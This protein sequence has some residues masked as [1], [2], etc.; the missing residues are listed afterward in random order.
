[1][2]QAVILGVTRFGLEIWKKALTKDVSRKTL[3]ALQGRLCNTIAGAPFRPPYSHSS[4]VL[5]LASLSMTLKDIIAEKELNDEGSPED[6]AFADF[7]CHDARE[8]CVVAPWEKRNFKVDI[9]VKEKVI[10]EAN[11]TA[12]IEELRIYTD[13]SFIDEKRMYAKTGATAVL[14][15]DLGLKEVN[16]AALHGSANIFNAEMA[17]VVLPP[18]LAK[19]HLKTEHRR[20]V[21]FV[22]SQSVIKVLQSHSG[23]YGVRVKATNMLTKLAEQVE[24]IIKGV[25]SHC[26]IKGNEVADQIDKIAAKTG[27]PHHPDLNHSAKWIISRCFRRRRRDKLTME[28]LSMEKNGLLSGSDLA[29]R[30]ETPR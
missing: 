4:A 23:K 5:N 11:E 9:P 29:V 10:S 6:R 17:G 20:L 28:W 2:Y 16:T 30:G 21:I 14:L 15:D 22:D 19:R 26:E 7:V 3:D 1:M 18:E 8:V 24:V 12:D 27:R 13:G 25:L